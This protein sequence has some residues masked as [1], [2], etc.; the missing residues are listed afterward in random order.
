MRIW[1]GH[2]IPGCRPS[3]TSPNWSF[4]PVSYDPPGMNHLQADPTVSVY[5]LVKLP[6]NRWICFCVSPRSDVCRKRLMIAVLWMGCQS[7][8]HVGL[9]LLCR[10]CGVSLH[11]RGFRGFHKSFN[12]RRGVHVVD[13][14]GAAV[15]K[16]VSQVVS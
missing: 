4:S 1:S 16:Q 12:A 14:A 13:Q 7:L 9:H 8:H 10:A 2:N 3:S 6:V 11:P 15:K 5:A